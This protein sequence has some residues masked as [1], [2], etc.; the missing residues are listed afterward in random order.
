MN[1][2]AANMERKKLA[3][4]IHVAGNNG[5]AMSG[6]PIVVQ[7]AIPRLV[8]AV[9]GVPERSAESASQPQKK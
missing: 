3:M 8:A 2:D 6:R 1:P 7:I 4:T 5:T 9:I